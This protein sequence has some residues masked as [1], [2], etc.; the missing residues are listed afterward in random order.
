MLESLKHLKI[1][2]KEEVDSPGFRYAVSKIPSNPG[3]ARG[4]VGSQCDDPQTPLALSKPSK[5]TW[6]ECEM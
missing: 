2:D 6:L 3:A 4:F 5:L 1:A